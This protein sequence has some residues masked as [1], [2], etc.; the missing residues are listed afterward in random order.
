MHN[1]VKEMQNMH[2]LGQMC[3]LNQLCVL[4]SLPDEHS[5]RICGAVKEPDSFFILSLRTHENNMLKDR[6][7]KS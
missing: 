4:L 2:E 5:K 3:R 7:S 6:L 1:I